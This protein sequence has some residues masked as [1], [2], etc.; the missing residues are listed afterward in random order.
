MTDKQIIKLKPREDL[1]EK[2]IKEKGN[3]KCIFY[4]DDI[5][6]KGDK[7]RDCV[8]CARVEY[9]S[10][11]SLNWDNQERLEKI[12]KQKIIECERWKKAN[13]EKNE[14]LAKLGCPTTA[15][16]RRQVFTLQQ[17][18]DQLK[19]ENEAKVQEC[20]RLKWYLNKIRYQELSN[21]D[22]D[23]DEHET[24][25]IDTEY[26]NIINLVK[27]ALNERSPEDCRYDR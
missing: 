4:S 2:I 11:Y 27:E 18:I 25:C 8:N 13:D 15:T 1:N 9:N 6:R 3:T 5:C 26:T 22:I 21:L 14:L 23:Y 24:N 10:L 20:D 7:T 16:A 17:Q 19:V 12:I